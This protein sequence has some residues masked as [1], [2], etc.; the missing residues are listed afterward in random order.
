MRVFVIHEDNKLTGQSKFVY[1]P[2]RL[3]SHSNDKR[4][5]NIDKFRTQDCLAITNKN[6]LY[7]GESLTYEYRKGSKLWRVTFSRKTIV[8]CRP[9]LLR[10]RSNY[11]QPTM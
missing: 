4:F 2:Q 7:N 5:I 10:D 6:K 11:V 1:H 9:F 3:C 8:C